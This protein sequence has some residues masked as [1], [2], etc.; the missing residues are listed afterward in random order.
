ML[1]CAQGCCQAPCRTCTLFSPSLSLHCDLSLFCSESSDF[2]FLLCTA[3][4]H[5]HTPFLLFFLYLYEDC[6]ISNST[7]QLLLYLAVSPDAYQCLD[8][9][10]SPCSASTHY[11]LISSPTHMQSTYKALQL[12][13]HSA[14]PPKPL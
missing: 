13:T 8:L 11:G 7:I 6:F 12:F 3:A 9:L 5:A 4:S 14:Q 2:L 10:I 1:V